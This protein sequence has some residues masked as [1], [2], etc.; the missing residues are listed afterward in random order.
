MILSVINIATVGHAYY[1]TS[2][3]ASYKSVFIFLKLKKNCINLEATNLP[4]YQNLYGKCKMV[5]I[6]SPVV[7]AIFKNPLQKQKFESD[8]FYYL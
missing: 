8:A 6:S 1:S 5:I 2:Y 7:A 4:F 3:N